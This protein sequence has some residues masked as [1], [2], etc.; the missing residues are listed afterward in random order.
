MLHGKGLEFTLWV[1]VVRTGVYPLNGTARA[2]W[3]KKSGVVFWMQT[4]AKSFRVLVKYQ[5]PSNKEACYQ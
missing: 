1:D 3:F 2:V 4:L 5:K